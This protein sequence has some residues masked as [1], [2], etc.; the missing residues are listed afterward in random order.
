MRLEPT[1]FG[2]SA[3]EPSKEPPRLNRPSLG[4]QPMRT[5]STSKAREVSVCA[6]I[7]SPF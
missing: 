6:S 4:G 5:G 2:F 3:R 7:F 1:A